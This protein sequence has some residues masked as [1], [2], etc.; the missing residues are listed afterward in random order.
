MKRI[1]VQFFLLSSLTISIWSNEK[2]E[3]S[4]QFGSVGTL[5]HFSNQIGGEFY[6]EILNLFL[7]HSEKISFKISPINIRT[8]FL[9]NEYTYSG[10]N[11]INLSLYKN[12]INNID[13]VFG[14]FFSFQ[15]LS[16]NNRPNWPT[17]DAKDFTFST[18]IKYIQKTNNYNFIGRVFLLDYDLGYRYNF[19]TGHSFYIAM[20]VDLLSTIIFLGSII[21]KENLY[22]YRE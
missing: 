14:L 21:A 20:R 22:K 3:L 9:N 7:D 6:M 2:H 19:Y 16:I 5:M 10:I 4:L 15:Y 13:S 1:I 11:F 12:I 8:H 17:F 18:G